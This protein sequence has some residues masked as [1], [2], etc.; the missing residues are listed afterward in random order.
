MTFEC[1]T[2]WVSAS[3]AVPLRVRESG[4]D[5]A[6]VV[7]GRARRRWAWRAVV[8]AG[9]AVA[10]ITVQ[11]PGAGRAADAGPDNARVFL[12]TGDGQQRLSD[13]GSVAFRTGGASELSIGVDPDRRYQQIE[14]FG[15]SITDS[16]AA[17]LYRLNA[18]KRDEVMHKLFDR[19][20]GIGLSYLRQ[21]IGASDFVD[22]PHYTYD[23]VPAG[24]TDFQLQQFSIEHDRAQILPLL[25][26]ARALNPALKVV[27]AAWSPPAWMKTNGSLVGGRL[28]DDDR[29]YDAYGRY[30]VKFLQAYKAAGVPVNAISVQNEPQNRLP[31]GYP[32]MYM[33]VADQARMIRVL[34]PMLQQAGLKT[35]IWAYD[36]NWALHPDDIANTPPGEDPEPNYPFDVMAPPDVAKWVDGVAWHCYAGDP[37]RQ[38][39][40][41][42]RFP[43]EK[44][45]FT[46]CS[47]S[48]GASDPPAKYFADTL[49]WQARN[50]TIG[51][52]RNGSRNAILWNLALDENSGPHRGGCETCTGLV[53]IGPGQQ[54]SYN[55]EYYTLGHA[56]RFLQPGAVRID[57]SSYGQT[58]GGNGKPMT[59]AFRNPDGSVVLVVLNDRDESQTLAVSTRGGHLSYTMPGGALATFV[60]QDSGGGGGGGGGGGSEPYRDP[61]L[62]VA[63][64]VGDLLSRMSLDDKIGQMTQVERLAA[65]PSDVAASRIGSVLSGGGSAPSPNTAASW[66][67]MYD[68]YQRASTTTPLGIPIIYGVDAVH[69]HNNV[70]GAT[71]FPHNIGLGATRDPDLVQKIGRATAE[72]VS[73][74]GID[75]DFAPCLCVARDD[76]WGRTYESF[77]EK[78]ELPSAMT[79][80]ITGLQGSSLNGPASVLATAKHYVGDGGTTDG[81][82]Q[83]DTQLSEA[84][85]RAIHLPPFRE[86]VSRGVGSVMISYSSWN[87][88]KMHE[89]RDLITDVLKGELGFKGFV[90]SDWRG[91]D[92]IDRQSGFT[93]DEVRKAINAGIDM[94]MVPYDYGHFMDLLKTEVQ[95]GRVS[96]ARI[97][98]AVRRILTK[99]FELGL[100]EH[101]L[102]DRSYTSTVGSAA[103]R[104]IARQAVRESQVLLKNRGNV[105]PLS[106]T[107]KV[108]VAGKNADDA[109]NQS[110]GWTISWQGQSG[111]IPGAT[112]I[113]QGIRAAVSPGTT[114]TYNRAGDG[115]DGSYKAAI[116]VVGET[117]YA[118]FQGDRRNG[119]GLDSDDLNTLAKLKAAGVPLVVVLVSGRPLDI[120][121]QI[122]VWDAVVQSWLPGSEGEGVADVL[123]GDQPFTGKLPVSWPRS[124]SEEP[125]NDGDGKQPLFP[126]GY[127]LTADGSGGGGNPGPQP[128]PATDTIL[129]SEYDEQQGTQTEPCSDVGCGQNVGHVT[130]GDYIASAAVDFGATAPQS[131]QT[132]L[133]S[134]AAVTGTIEYRLDTRTGPVIA[135]QHV[136]NTGGWQTWTTQTVHLTA[137]AT[138]VHKLYL[139]FVGPTTD[140]FVNLHWFRFTAS[141]G[142]G[143]GGGGDIWPTAWY[144]IT[145]ASTGRCLDARDWGTSNGTALQQWQCGGTQTNQ[146]WQ[147]VPT[148]GGYYRV[149]NR[150]APALVWDVTG[151]PSPTA[152]GTPIQLWTWV[153]PGGTNQQWKPETLSEGRWR[154]EARHSGKCLELPGASSANGARVVQAACNSGAAQAFRLSAQ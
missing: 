45:Y 69:G 11:E 23:D 129:A 150:N 145:N 40:L 20:Q 104:V 55:A 37:S 124:A 85:L 10:A 76:R 64:R 113:L 103:H 115:I 118:E 30:L 54:V 114:V 61:S 135:R 93:A 84:D 136:K 81:V 140:D 46:E 94:V 131:V 149:V 142:G 1:R 107:G 126:Y 73:G 89:N 137:N 14:G 48:H 78:P 92:Q 2:L 134:G 141:A 132:R 88:V 31:K 121:G 51:A 13:R 153:P 91:I 122:D 8:A 28:K 128:H 95:A 112:S 68:A 123:F 12:T 6:P 102:T 117:P 15:A 79:S 116:A 96:Q 66:A 147:F 32:G 56:S 62:P 110:G 152:D 24:R 59:V 133:A 57:S 99:K 143:G 22:E 87:G 18:A 21:P 33:P 86:A 148:D 34:G 35:K 80:V 75:W 90:V 38:T 105:L 7:L 154:L 25:R 60:W 9:V 98:D 125:I 5:M 50:V 151:G 39:E 19:S 100:F 127:G 27:A 71:I 65:S 41:H 119:F 139:T 44:T 63:Q 36:H 83:G 109:G 17:V 3:A 47:G 16:S 120:A 108:F 43:D 53:Q 106:K 70:A 29:V 42:D 49:R 74:T 52:I 77:G 26:R 58:T 111:S 146:Q 4:G 67:D 97:D 72:E 130:N 138:G 144:R 82:D 101:P